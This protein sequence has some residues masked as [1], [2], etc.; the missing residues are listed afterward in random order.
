MIDM[1]TPRRQ[2][3]QGFCFRSDGFLGM[4]EEDIANPFGEQRPSWFA[5]A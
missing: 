5:C 4:V 1:L 3:E 2:N